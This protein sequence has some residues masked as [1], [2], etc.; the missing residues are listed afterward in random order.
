MKT[1][2]IETSPGGSSNVD[3][4]DT[5]SNTTTTVYSFGSDNIQVGDNSGNG[6]NIQ[7]PVGL[8]TEPG[9]QVHSITINDYADTA[10]RSVTITDSSITGLMPAAITYSGSIAEMSILAGSC[11]LFRHPEHAVGLPYRSSMP[12]AITSI[13]SATRPASSIFGARSISTHWASTPSISTSTIPPT[14]PAGRQRSP[15]TR[16]RAW[17]RGRSGIGGPSA[18][19]YIFG[20]TGSN[21]FNIQGVGTGSLTDLYTSGSDNVHIGDS[22]GTADIAGSLS[23]D[24]LSSTKKPAVVVDDA[25]GQGTP[26]RDDHGRIDHRPLAPGRSTTAAPWPPSPSRGRRAGDLLRRQHGRGVHDLP[27]R[28]RLRE[29]RHRGRRQRDRRH[30]GPARRGGRRDLLRHVVRRRQCR[31]IAADGDADIQLRL[32]PLPGADRSTP[33]RSSGSTST[34]GPAASPTTSRGRRAG[35][36]PRSTPREPTTSPS[37]P[38]T[39]SRISRVS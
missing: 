36:S 14:R 17:R 9:Y 21:T 13:R 7:G 30:S 38:P 35:C 22:A 32:G 18:F 39:A 8:V 27:R 1:I 25:A 33:D 15:R 2:E 5:A 28:Q 23:I 31:F 11:R 3:V 24:N 34:A 20:G 19:L 10:T 12:G 16:S 6:Q 26:P 37:A 4:E 29:Q